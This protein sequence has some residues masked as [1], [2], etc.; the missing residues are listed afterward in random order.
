M[1]S[2]S[3]WPHWADHH[4]ICCKWSDSHEHVGNW[5]VG[6]GQSWLRLWW[7]NRKSSW[8]IFADNLC[9]HRCCSVPGKRSY[10]WADEVTSER[11]GGTK[12]GATNDGFVSIGA[13]A[14][15]RS[16]RHHYRYCIWEVLLQLWVPLL[17]S[18]A[19][20]IAIAIVFEK[21]CC[22]WMPPSGVPLRSIFMIHW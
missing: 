21:C 4:K 9:D 1:T 15:V 3:A 18:G 17:E 5:A 11:A 8:N 16:R 7:T 2:W 13:I 19:A 12:M 14:G 20:D 22:I 10:Q 6:T